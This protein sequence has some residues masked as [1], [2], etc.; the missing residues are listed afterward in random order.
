MKVRDI[1]TTRVVRIGAREP[2]EAAART[3]THY[4][5]GAL[6][7][8]GDDGRLCG[9][10]TDR[11]LVTRCMAAGRS[12]GDVK[13]QDIMTGR[14]IT[15]GPDMDVGAAAHLMGREQVRRLPVVENGKLCGMVSLADLAATENGGLDAADALADITANICKK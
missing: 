8:C 1:M 5:I 10:V 7:V 2:V 12:A 15:V 4:N 9:V 6:P 3:L 14:L 13:V 11:D